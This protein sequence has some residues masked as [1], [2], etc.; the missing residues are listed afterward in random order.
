MK[1]KSCVFI[2][3]DI[4]EEHFE[5]CSNIADALIAAEKEYEDYSEQISE[6][7]VT[8]RMLTTDADKLDYALAASSGFLAGIVDVFLIGKP[9]ESPIG[10][11]TDK[12]FEERVKDFAKLCGWKETNNSLSSAIRFLERKFDIPYDQRGAG[13]IG[14]V[15]WNLTP[16][17]HHFK[18]LAH[19][20]TLLGLFFSIIDQF[21]N[22][23]HFVSD[24]KLISLQEA[25][26]EFKLIGSNVPSKFFCAFVNWFGHLVSDISGSSGSTGR[27]VG[28]PSV[29]WSWT[30]DLIVI[31]NKLNLQVS[32]FEKS[33]NE[34]AVNIFNKGFDTRFQTAQAIPV[35]FNE[36]IVRLLYSTRRLIK[37]LVDENS[38]YISFERIWDACEPFSNATIKRMLTVAHGSFCIID[39]S[40]ALIRG[41]VYGGGNLNVVEF[42]LRINVV[43]IGRFI[44]SLC[45][46]IDR[47]GKS[48]KEEEKIYIINRRRV[49]TLDYIDELKKLS[50]KYDDKYLFA[51]IDDLENSKM[52]REAFKSSVELA[53]K[54]SVPEEQILCTKKD[55]DSY[56]KKGNRLC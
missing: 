12:W 54:R 35:L 17:N 4:T 3:L 5:F 11:I 44:I 16:G 23:S 29:F 42:A 43:G 24:G 45:G 9:N 7:V 53:R 40:D 50:N 52:Y 10:K 14:S 49:I 33:I 22:T 28:I 2:E 36:L 34:L 37:F 56:F 25:D 31:K 38:R 26:R 21:A 15:I 55:I 18:S 30:N 6:S 32:D 39:M 20:P 47:S 41:L 48:K 46:E 19:N 8:L 27:G 51:V 13:D 1:E